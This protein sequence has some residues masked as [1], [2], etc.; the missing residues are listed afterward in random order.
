MLKFSNHFLSRGRADDLIPFKTEME[1][2]VVLFWWVGVFYTEEMLRGVCGSEQQS[3]MKF[4]K[5]AHEWNISEV[6]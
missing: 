2:F 1:V 3:T 6:A 4:P 5:S